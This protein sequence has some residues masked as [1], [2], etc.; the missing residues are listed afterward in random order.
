MR[1]W[2]A[3]ATVLALVVFLAGCGGRSEAPAA[4]GPASS[5]G[6]AAGGQEQVK[7]GAGKGSATGESLTLKVADSLPVKH[8]GSARLAVPWMKRVEELTG[9]RVRF[10]YYPAEQLGKLNDMLNMVRTGVADIVYILPPQF[11]AEL[12]LNGMVTL[13]GLFETAREGSALYAAMLK[14]G[15][16]L[17]EFRAL[18]V[19][20]LF[21]AVAPTYEVYT[22]KKPVR[23]PTDIKGL[24]IRIAGGA[25]A[26]AAE[27]VGALPVSVPTPDQYT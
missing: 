11:P 16:L 2:A 5:G 24:K 9:G 18:G 6:T 13:P 17:D 19:Q 21:S 4:G 27:A 23:L 22:V 3:A 12:P 1:I 7:S 20:P 8:W 15:P 10:E 26:A 25:Q 14:Q